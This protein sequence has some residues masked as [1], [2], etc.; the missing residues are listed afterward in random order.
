MVSIIPDGLNTESTLED[1]VPVLGIMWNRKTD[2]LSISIRTAPISENLSKREVLLLTQTIFDPLGFLTPVLLTAK[3]QEIWALKVDR[4][5]LLPEKIRSKFLKWYN[6]LSVLANLKL[7][8]T[9]R[10]WG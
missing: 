1:P 10:I 8:P 6:N 7:P 2:D 9:N 4:D 3:L 5:I